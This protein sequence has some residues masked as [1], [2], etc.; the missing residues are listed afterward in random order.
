MRGGKNEKVLIFY[1]ATFY[2]FN[3]QIKED[4][5]ESSAHSIILKVRLTCMK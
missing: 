1:D 5:F 3:V 2:Y 4:T